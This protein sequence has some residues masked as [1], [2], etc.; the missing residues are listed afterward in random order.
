MDIEVDSAFPVETISLMAGCVIAEGMGEIE[1]GVDC[2]GAMAAVNGR[3][4][5][6][7]RLIGGWKHG[8]NIKIKKVKAH[9]ERRGGVWQEDETG[10]WTADKIAGGGVKN[11]HV[12]T[13]TSIVKLFGSM[14]SIAIVDENNIP[15]IGSLMRR[16]SK[17]KRVNYFN[18][19][20]EYREDKGKAGIWKGS[21]MS[22]SYKMMGEIGING[23]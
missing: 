5:K 21:S 12:A 7:K 9:P 3:N 15:F 11:V 18:K 17:M 4:K 2:R 23:G 1:I 14:G 20:D 10:I 16:S 8:S 19:R 6:F 13:A 22:L